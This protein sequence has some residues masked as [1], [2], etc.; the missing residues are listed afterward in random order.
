MSTDA[1]D[2]TEEFKNLVTKLAGAHVEPASIDEE[3]LLPSPSAAIAH[4]SQ[5]TK[6]A[7]HISRGIFSVSEKL[8]RMTMLA[9]KKSLFDDVSPEINKLTAT[10]KADIGTLNA[11]IDRLHHWVDS[12]GSRQSSL[13]SNAIVQNLQLE[14]ANA[15]KSFTEILQMRTQALKDQ[16]IRRKEFEATGGGGGAGTATLRQRYAPPSLSGRLLGEEEIASLH[17]V[18]DGQT[19]EYSTEAGEFEQK[20]IEHPHVLHDEYLSQRAQAVESIEKTIVELGQMYQRLVSI[21]HMQEEIT[22]RIDEHMDTALHHVIEGETE[23]TKHL[24]SVSGYK[25]L[26]FKVFFILI[27]F[28]IFFMV[29]VA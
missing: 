17:A 16:N 23:L 10:V 21:V 14:L 6:A 13:N 20:Q 11:E 4:K 5:F 24:A 3:P 22:L 19:D 18:S 26:I 15:T 29:F 8:E 28:I 1:R 27:A 9:K 7:Q 25:W 2:R 12:R